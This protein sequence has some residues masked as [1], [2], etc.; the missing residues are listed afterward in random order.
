MTMDPVGERTHHAKVAIIILNWNGLEDT[1][2]C[3]QSLKR[4]NYPNYEV[5]IIDNGSEKNE[6]EI[7]RQRFGDYAHVIQNEKNVGFA[8]GNNIGIRYVLKNSKPDYILLLNNDTIV[9]S[10]FLGALVGA[11]DRDPK[12]GIL[13]PKLLS[14]TQPTRFQAAGGI[15]NW[16]SGTTPQIGAGE[17]DKGQFNILREVDWVPG[18]ALL[19]KREVIDAIGLMYPGYF[20]FFEES[21]WCAKSRKAG[22]R[23]VYVPEGKVWHKGGPKTEGHST[24]RLYYMTRNR[25]LFVK[26]NATTF[27][28]LRF[29]T[30]FLL[31]DLWSTG[32]ILLVER[33]GLKSL[34]VFYKGAYDG[35]WLAVKKQIPDTEAPV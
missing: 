18:C 16:W 32:I 19:I 6:A 15:I 11:G 26:R 9:D 1:M 7:L 12:T 34:K 28:F 2:E 29:L 3:L 31:I 8:Q 22:Y 33:G 21:E 27:Q 14:C 23:V 20:L 10:E 35:I 24:V 25:F 13:G 5:I 30:R 4:I 17:T